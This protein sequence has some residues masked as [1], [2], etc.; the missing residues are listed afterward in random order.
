MLRNEIETKDTWDLTPLFAD[1]AAWEAAY[2]NAEKA[3]KAFPPTMEKMLDSAQDLYAACKSLVECSEQIDRVYTYSHLRFSEDTTNN[4]ARQLMGRSQNLLTVFSETIA[5]FDTILLTLEQEQLDGFFKD[6]PALEQEYGI[7]LRNM[8]RYKPHT[9]TKAEEQL[10][11]A[12]SKERATAEETY[13]SL[14]SSDLKFGTI[15]DEDGQE[16]EL[17]DTNYAM[18]MR[19]S[20]RE[21]RKAAF[22]TLYRTYDQ[23]R[24]TF[25]SLYAG[26]IESEKVCAK[27]R[28]YGSALEASLFP[29][30][31]TPEIYNNIIDSISG[32]LDVLFRYYR[33]KRRVLGLDEMHMY[34]IYIPLNEGEKRRF[35]Y[36]EAVDEVLDAVSIFGQEYVDI[37]RKGYEKRWVDVYPN[38]GK[39]G[40]A[41]SG[42]CATSEP[43]ILLNFQGLDDD[44]ST[45]AHES[46]HSMH[47]YFTRTNNP[48]QYADYRIFVAEVPSTVNELVLAYHRLEHSDDRNEKLGI[49]GNLLDLY[50]STIYRQIMF[51]EFERETHAMS[52][53]GEV[54]TADLLCEKYYAL[55]QKYFGGEVVLDDEIAREWMRVPHFYYN[56]Y[57]YKYAIGLTAAS[58]IVR[59]I[60]NHEEGALESYFRFLKL[61]STKD[62]IESLKVAG[63]DMTKTDVFDSAVEMFDELITEFEKLYEEQ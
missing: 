46:G 5:P 48:L 63:V 14:T 25:A 55:N 35:T 32:H 51:A 58:H 21:V 22:T 2:Q 8:F 34:D 29:D 23:F 24:N 61:G 39:V 10:M 49:L 6:L 1:T 4:E 45:L 40:G 28:H 20:D 33:L 36:P 44:V 12:F 41:F 52:E 17:T 31:M 26:Q 57:V 3:I 53:A 56:F 16:A 50:K 37:L 9:L 43:Y 54:L 38:T 15:R 18:Y 42:G 27:V 47:S 13:E 59:R 11:A 60:R 19:S 30:H 7:M 62:P